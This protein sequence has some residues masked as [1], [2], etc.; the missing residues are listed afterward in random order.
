MPRERLAPQQRCLQY[1][2]VERT[3]TILRIPTIHPWGMGTITLAV[4]VG[5]LMAADV[6]LHVWVLVGMA[7]NFGVGRIMGMPTMIAVTN[8]TFIPL[9]ITFSLHSGQS[10]EHI[11]FGYFRQLI[12][13]LPL[14]GGQIGLATWYRRR[15]TTLTVPVPRLPRWTAKSTTDN[16]V[17]SNESDLQR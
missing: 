12:W 5:G 3:V 8:M 2:A 7:L 4:H 11:E 14:L 17:A 9:V 13:L 1:D 15:S 10:I 16:D 6:P